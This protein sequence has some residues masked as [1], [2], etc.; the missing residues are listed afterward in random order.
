M[1]LYGWD[2]ETWSFWPGNM[3]P[4]LVCSSVSQ[5]RPR[6]ERVLDR[7]RSR[8]WLRSAFS[9]P[10]VHIVGHNIAYDLGVA[11][12]D[13]PELIDLVFAALEAGRLHDTGIC[14]SLIDLARGTMGIDPRSG[15]KIDADEEGAS[16]PLTVL[17]ARYLP[18]EVEQ[19]IELKYGPTPG[20]SGTGS[21]TASPC[22]A[23]PPA[24]RASTPTTTPASRSASS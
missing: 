15:R 6:T 8:V 14:E 22:T 4:P 5:E 10:D 18:E 16:Y 11:S 20:A 24:A 7:N 17:V 19:S 3:A 1:K 13:Q 2:T 12:A 23:W 9:R 21:S